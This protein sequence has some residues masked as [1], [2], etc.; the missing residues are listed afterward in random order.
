MSISS[1]IDEIIAQRKG[2]GKW[3]GQGMVDQVRK[4]KE[5][6][7]SLLDALNSYQNQHNLILEGIRNKSGIYYLL[8]ASNPDFE[9]NIEEATPQKAIEKVTSAIAELESLEKR[10]DRETINISVVGLARQGKSRLLQTICNVD[11]AII[12]ADSGSDCTGAKSAICNEDCN[13][14]ANVRFF[15]ESEMLNNIQKYLDGLNYPLHLGNINQIKSLRLDDIEKKAVT[16]KQSSYFDRLKDYVEHFEEYASYFGQEKKVE[17]SD[18]RKYVAQ[19]LEDGT[20]VYAY[21]SVKEVE[22]HTPYAYQDVGKIMLVDTIGLGDTAIGLRDKMI[23]TLINDS[24]AAILLRRP[25][26]CGDGIREGD[27]ELYDDLTAKMQGR[28]LKKWL[29]YVLNTFGNNKKA[30][31]Q[32]YENLSKKMGKTFHVSFLKQIDCA[33]VESVR[34]DLVEPLLQTLTD[35][36]SEID[37]GLLRHLNDKLEAAFIEVFALNDKLTKLANDDMLQTIEGGELFDTLYDGLKENLSASFKKLNDLYVDRNM[38]NPELEGSICDVL[39]GIRK[40]LPS[41]EYIVACLQQ[42]DIIEGPDTVYDIQ[43]N[44][45]RTKIRAEFDNVCNN[46]IVK[47]EDGI[48][49]QIVELFYNTG[50]LRNVPLLSSLPEPT[51]GWFESLRT[52][53]AK[54]RLKV[55][56]AFGEVLDY[57]LHIEG[58]LQYKVHCALDWLTPKNTKSAPE[59]KLVR[60]SDEIKEMCDEDRAS[61]ILETLAGT[62]PTIANELHN[63]ISEL[64]VIPNNSF[65][66]L[67]QKI[68][69]RL[70]YNKVGIQDLKNFYRA[71]CTAIWQDE[72]S[73]ISKKNEASKALIDITSCLSAYTNK[74][75]YM[76]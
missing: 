50:L 60:L 11:N 41:K 15:S 52:E 33:N 6:Y 1:R 67:I 38:V 10:F 12:P 5:F 18:I 19:Y 63:S 71:N 47:L 35:N 51:L 13:T 68:R 37:N 58:L 55:K 3:A 31:D 69:D 62:L 56:E 32:M 57:R 30:S 65:N 53:K 66:V 76:F 39:K 20:K 21:L 17:K 40:K 28:D 75:A 42:G 24:D 73:S 14:Y 23:D 44:E 45:L 54:D 72:F 49:N 27:N 48:R 61:V 34:C 59:G 16:A 43:A 70:F 36:L 4:K 26:D 2:L 25:D 46:S 7:E 74:A 8:T 9:D 64:L 29:F 22:I